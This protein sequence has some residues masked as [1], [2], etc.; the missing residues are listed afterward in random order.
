MQEDFEVV[1][2]HGG[3]SVNDGMLKYEREA[4]TLSFDLDIWSYFVIVSVVKELEYVGLKELWWGG[5]ILDD[6]LK[7]LCDDNG[8]MHTINLV[9]LNG[10]VH[11]FVVHTVYES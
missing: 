7:P 5:S 11:V 10:Q 8:A 1:F 2:H 3:K 4:S 9:M 6:R